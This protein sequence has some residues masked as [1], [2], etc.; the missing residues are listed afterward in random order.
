MNLILGIK[1]TINGMRIYIFP[2]LGVMNVAVIVLQQNELTR[3]IEPFEMAA[4]SNYFEKVYHLYRNVIL[5]ALCLVLILEIFWISKKYKEYSEI[6]D[7]IEGID[8]LISK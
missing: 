5:N 3:M 4:K 6:R 7:K 2:L 1:V 8:K